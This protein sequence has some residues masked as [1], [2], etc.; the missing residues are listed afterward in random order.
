MFKYFTL[1]ILSKRLLIC[2]SNK[3]DDIKEAH[4][5]EEENLGGEIFFM[6]E[7]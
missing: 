3:G 6:A 5:Q 1:W 7:T 2:N 4:E